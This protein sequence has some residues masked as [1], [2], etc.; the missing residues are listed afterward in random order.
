VMIDGSDLSLKDNIVL[1][2]KVVEIAHRAD[3]GV[4]GEVGRTSPTG[5]VKTDANANA[6]RQGSSLKRPA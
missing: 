5:S 2:K 1:T 3:L 6:T 4:E